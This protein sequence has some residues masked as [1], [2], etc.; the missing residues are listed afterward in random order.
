[1]LIAVYKFLLDA[2]VAPGTI[3][4]ILVGVVYIFE[5]QP[6]KAQVLNLQGSVSSLQRNQL[7]ERLDVTYSALCMNPGDPAV[8]ERIRDLQ[9]AYDAVVNPDT[10]GDR[11]NSPDCSLLMKL[12]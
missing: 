3:A 8:L 7:E 10:R 12:R 11:Y 4:L 5:I 6:V 1:M 2:K 9:Q